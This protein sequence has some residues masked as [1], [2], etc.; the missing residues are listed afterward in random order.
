MSVVDSNSLACIRVAEIAPGLAQQ[1]YG[2]MP[3][4]LRREPEVGPGFQL[5]FEL[6][7]CFRQACACGQCLSAG[8][9]PDRGIADAE[10]DQ[11]QGPPCTWPAARRYGEPDRCV[12]AMA[13]GE[14]A[15]GEHGLVAG[16]GEPTVAELLDQGVDLVMFSGD[17][18]L[19]GPQAGI[20][21]GRADLIQKLRKHPLY[22]ALRVDRL[23]LA[24]LEATLRGYLSGELPPAV[25]MIQ[26]EGKLLMP[27]LR[28]W[29]ERLKDAGIPSTIVED[30]GFAGGGSL[31]GEGLPGPVLCMEGPVVAL[32]RHLRLG[33]PA[34]LGRLKEGSLRLDPRTVREEEE[35]AL[36]TA[37]ITAWKAQNL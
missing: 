4:G 23:V 35:E 8:G 15:E 26:V 3:L 5:G 10:K 27:R 36:L 22:R 24:A 30:V 2:E 32:A 29:Q 12:I 14:L 33:R 20:L 34:V 11:A 21:V 7:A 37:I 13:A 17:K 1:V 19:G 31:P 16:L 6:C 9:S 25:Q 18:L 28:R